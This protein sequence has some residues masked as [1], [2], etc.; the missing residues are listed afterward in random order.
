MIRA[1]FFRCNDRL[2]GFEISGHSGYAEQGEDI[3]CAA[4]SCAVEL[5]A[6]AITVIEGL[7]ADVKV[8]GDTVMLTVSQQDIERAEKFLKALKLQLEN[9]RESY[10]DYILLE[11]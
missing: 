10:G 3:V 7:H 11:E 5:T 1:R 4:V 9:I 8:S 2:C 6:N